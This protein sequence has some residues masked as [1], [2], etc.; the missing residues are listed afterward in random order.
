MS[1][2]IPRINITYLMESEVAKHSMAC[3]L[4]SLHL[5]IGHFCGDALVKLCGR[6]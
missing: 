6:P 2:L 1:L 5:K 4:A 3:M